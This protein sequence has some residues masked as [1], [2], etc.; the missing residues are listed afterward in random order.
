MYTIDALIWLG[1]KVI[2]RKS[3]LF[4]D[5]KIAKKFMK[6]EYNRYLNKFD[7]ETV[8]ANL[9]LTDYFEIN[10]SNGSDVTYWL[11]KT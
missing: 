4:K 10:F 2:K 7:N 5:I 8:I 3:F 1:D 9:Y 11:T 6:S